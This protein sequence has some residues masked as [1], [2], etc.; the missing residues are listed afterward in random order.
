MLR[1]AVRSSFR[2]GQ[3]AAFSRPPVS[4]RKKRGLV[5]MVQGPPDSGKTVTVEAM[6]HAYNKALFAI[7][8]NELVNETDETTMAFEVAKAWDCPPLLDDADILQSRARHDSRVNQ[9]AARFLRILDTFPGLI[10]L[11]TSHP[12]AL[13]ENVKSRVHLTICFKPLT[14]GQTRNIFQLSFDRLREEEH[15]DVGKADTESLAISDD[16]VLRFAEE[17]YNKDASGR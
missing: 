11:T 16:E 14:L 1:L 2:Q 5:V 9:H 15:Q 3:E 13:D 4:R 8:A 17:H 12:A 7:E 6:A 10:F